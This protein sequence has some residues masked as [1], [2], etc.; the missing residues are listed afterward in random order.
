MLRDRGRG[1]SRARSNGERERRRCGAQGQR[2]SRE[3]VDDQHENLPGC[4][5]SSGR[6]DP[7][8]SSWPHDGHAQ[9]GRRAS[10]CHRGQRE[11]ELGRN[12]DLHAVRHRSGEE[13]ERRRRRRGLWAGWLRPC[14]RR[15]DSQRGHD[16]KEDRPTHA[17]RIR[18]PSDP[19]RRA[20]RRSTTGTAH[21]L[22][23]RASVSSRAE[24]VPAFGETQGCVRRPG[25]VLLRCFREYRGSRPSGAQGECKRGGALMWCR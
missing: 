4:V 21:T 6:R 19:G 25:W 24:L 2:A 14:G 5:A 22:S 15:Q 1:L 3:T 9:A 11:V 16:H 12:R 8:K 18:L 20:T 13:R 10:E 7:L 17:T 23:S